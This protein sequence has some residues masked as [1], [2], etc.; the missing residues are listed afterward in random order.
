VLNENDNPGRLADE[1]AAAMR[2]LAGTVTDAPPLR[3]TAD[4]AGLAPAR[5]RRRPP[6]PRFRWSWGAPVL[7]A[8]AVVAVAVALVSVKDM[9]A[10]H[11]APSATATIRPATGTTGPDEGGLPG[12]YV[13]LHP[14]S[15]R[16]GA[17]AGL[18]VGDTVTGKTVAVIAP[19]AYSTIVSVSGAADDRTF[20]VVAA[21]TSGGPGL[22]DGFYLLTITPG[23][24]PAARLTQLPMEPQPGVIA[25]AL[26]AS[27]K[28]LAVATANRAVTGG[29]VIRELTV[30]SVATGR[31]SR[32]WSTTDTAAI[33]SDAMPGVQL[34][35]YADQ[36]PALTWIDGDRAVAF[37]VLSR[38][39]GSPSRYL[40]EVRSVNIAAAGGD[41]LADS[42]VIADLGG[43][44]EGTGS[45]GTFFP[46]LSGNGTTLFCLMSGGPDGHT[47]PTT[48][49]WV[50][51]WRPMQTSLANGAEWRFF[52][53]PKELGVPAG[54]AVYPATVWASST[55]ATLLIEW[56]VVTPASG[57]SAAG[58]VQSVRFG[59]L[60]KGKN[61]WTFT[62]LPTPAI[63]AA[64][65]PPGIAW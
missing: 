45:C 52:A 65:G 21:P 62:P 46:A 35:Q 64:G 8:A 60:S 2:D 32:S 15:G 11:V 51:E 5:P 59:E 29:P 1:T 22:D 47:S 43:S 16:S 27:G 56:S 17:P 42:K 36:Y 4:D 48:V 61:S 7:A 25:M 55:G 54:S 12:Y 28:E 23:G 19:P 53:Y 41:L 18:I 10:G 37:P 34:G 50:L 13:A 44:P 3:L 31:P 24:S 63:L 39:G 58:H 14:V 9:P 26:S 49:R 40:L 30:Y 38:S 57:G 20:A 6:G 33:V